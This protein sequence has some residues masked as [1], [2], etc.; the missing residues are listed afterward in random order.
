[1]VETEDRD[2]PNGLL[3]VA[4][5]AEGRRTTFEFVLGT[6][7]NAIVTG[8]I[9][10]GTHLVQATV[11]NELGVSTTPV[12]EALRHLAS[13]GIVD[14][15][16][17]RGAVVRSIDLGDMREVYQLRALLEPHCIRLAIDAISPEALEHAEDLHERM[18][19]ETDLGAWAELN[20]EFHSTLCNAADSP[21]LTRLLQSLHAVD[22]LY[23]G[24]GLRAA[25]HP[26][27]AGNRD[28]GL[29][30]EA[31]KEKDA[32]AAA[33]VIASHIQATIDTLDAEQRDRATP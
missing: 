3:G 25:S 29:I 17:H 27:E 22:V 12:R 7:R 6:L 5:A 11:A 13:E 31:F 20:R 24:V 15:D 9:P 21:R 18:K 2:N 10:G 33:E 16:S 14:I 23:V 28:H 30:V 8:Q 19:A 26:M 1:M 4:N 32:D